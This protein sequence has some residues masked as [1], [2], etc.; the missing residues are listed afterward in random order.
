VAALVEGDVR[1]YV[2]ST[3]RRF[4][5]ID[6]VDGKMK[7]AWTYRIPP[8]HADA[9][10][11]S[12]ASL[13]PDGSTVVVP[14]GDGA[15][16]ALDAEDGTLRWRFRAT[17]ASEAEHESGV[18]VNSFEGNVRHSPDGERVF[19]G[20]DNASFYCVDARTGAELWRFETGMM[21]WS[22]ASFLREATVVVFG[23]LDG[24]VYA[25]EAASG[26]LVAERNT[27]GEVKSSPV[28]LS[29][30]GDEVV[31]CNS[32]GRIER[33]ALDYSSSSSSSSAW[34]VVWAVDLD[35]E[36]YGSPAF[37]AASGR[38]F[39]SDMSGAISAL[40]AATGAV[41]WRTPTYGYTTASPVVTADGFVVV[42]TSAGLLLALSADDGGVAGA[43]K[44]SKTSKPINASPIVLPNGVVVVGTYDGDVHAVPGSELLLGRIR[45][46]EPLDD[47]GRRTTHVRVASEPGSAIVSLRLHV[48]GDGAYRERAGAVRVRVL[49]KGNDGAELRDRFE[50][51]LSAD[52]KFVNLVPLGLP[53]PPPAVV[54]VWG[55]TRDLSTTWLADRAQSP[56]G[57]AFRCTP[58]AVAWGTSGSGGTS[59]SKSDS[60]P[61]EEATGKSWDVRAMR[62]GQPTVLETYIPAALD[63]QG[64]VMSAF[65]VRPDRKRAG[66]GS[67][68]LLFVPALPGDGPR[69]RDL[70]GLEAPTVLREP[71]KVVAMRARY[72][73]DSFVAVSEGAF[74]FSA[75]GG[76]IPMSDFRVFGTIKDAGTSTRMRLDFIAMASCLGVRGNGDAYS[77]PT[78]LVNQLCDG[79]LQLK[80]VGSGDAEPRQ[81]QQQQ[82]G[83]HPLVV[84][85][86]PT[87]RV[88][89]S[90]GSTAAADAATK[91]CN[92]NGS[93]FVDGTLVPP[94]PSCVYPPPPFS[95][96]NFLFERDYVRA[97]CPYP[98]IHPNVVTAL[99]I[100][101]TAGFLAVHHLT[102]GGLGSL[103]AILALI[104]VRTAADC[105]DGQI[106]RACDKK[107]PIGASLD[108]LSDT[109]FWAAAVYLMV[110]V[111]TR[112]RPATAAVAAAVVLGGF[113]LAGF[114]V[115]ALAVDDD[116]GSEGSGKMGWVDDHAA[117]K[118][119]D[120]GAIAAFSYNNV[121]LLNAGVCAVLVGAFLFARR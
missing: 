77:F 67:M 24:R 61:F 21:I 58:I 17:D 69:E 71:S 106:A 110:R 39:V 87:G 1:V 20:C 112:C 81:K 93:V 8:S 33:L 86:A 6:L 108:T 13:S 104:A 49:A 117:V 57:E 51:H 36:I 47:A 3:N 66:S 30:A 98:A 41:L 25:L 62:A 43:S 120:L 103:L 40:D 99:G 109:L 59:G 53:L 118:R 32:N 83:G 116:G 73:G 23:S 26:R 121:V 74:T 65:D 38:L 42:G 68:R 92:S 31:V 90:V 100:V 50:V 70:G 79:K 5:R 102:D 91:A 107:T 9:L 7:V 96:D 89:A 63:A 37:A 46:L 55:E 15:L 16:H 48:Y 101:A 84:W 119:G 44:V 88:E 80:I 114:C 85:A 18:V 72:L 60:S 105:L 64:F 12:A 76:T 27:G 28:A 78:E 75:M 2:G 56:R 95:V 22:V 4:C 11:D 97:A 115:A 34:R 10:I 82:G 113:F 35:T 52:G 14:G 94:D 54:T 45:T 111:V 19:A 29:L